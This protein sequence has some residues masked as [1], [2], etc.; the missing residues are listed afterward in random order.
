[1]KE[2]FYRCFAHLMWLWHSF[3]GR[4]FERMATLLL[5]IA[6]SITNPSPSRRRKKFIGV[7]SEGMVVLVGYYLT[8]KI[9][10]WMGYRPSHTLGLPVF[11]TGWL[12]ARM[13]FTYW[14][15]KSCSG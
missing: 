10:I 15:S 9:A 7:V 14:K 1:M 8:A 4:L 2:S 11:V 5:S 12:V 6:E 13:I 3:R